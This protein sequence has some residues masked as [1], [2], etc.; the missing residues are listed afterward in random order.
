MKK[1]SAES[2][3]NFLAD[4]YRQELQTILEKSPIENLEEIRKNF[5][6]SANRFL[7]HSKELNRKRINN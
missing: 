2:N 5:A 6:H 7:K 1:E 4:I 3:A